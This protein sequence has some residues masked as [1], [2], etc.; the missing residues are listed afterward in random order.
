MPDLFNG[1][2]WT[3]VPPWPGRRSSLRRGDACCVASPLVSIDEVS[4]T[5][6]NGAI[7]VVTTRRI[8]VADPHLEAHFPGFKIFPGV[9]VIES[10]RQAVRSILVDP[11]GRPPEIAAVHSVRFLAP[12]LPGDQMRLMAKL[13]PRS[14]RTFDVE[15]VAVRGDGGVAVR[16]KVECGSVATGEAPDNTDIRTCLPHGHPMLLVDRVVS[17]EPGR[18][19]VAIKAV[20]GTEPCYRDLPVDL[21]PESYAYPASLMLESF[22]QAA[23]IL[24]IE[25]A[26]GR[27]KPDDL[28]ILT[29]ARKCRI[30]GHAYPGDTLTHVARIDNVVGDT[31]LVEGDV[32]VGD[33][34]VATIESMMASIR[35]PLALGSAGESSAEMTAS[36]ASTVAD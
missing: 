16:L 26:G 10:L 6:S 21:P 13:I 29:S 28:V 14:E 34:R 22:G 7:D 32:W 4:A 30:E 23:A 19:I 35:T 3:F 25:S 1:A 20:S 9:F 33:R 2:Y 24:W 36:A 31:V 27:R 11:E 8:D 15:A 17:L 5:V 12:L 18:S